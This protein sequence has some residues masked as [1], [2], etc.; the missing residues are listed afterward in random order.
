MPRARKTKI[1]SDTSEPKRPR[2]RA[3][4]KKTKPSVTPISAEEIAAEAYGLF[5][6]RNGQ[7]GDALADWLAAERLVRDRRMNG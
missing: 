7:H 4:V 6:A 2:R 1:A 3:T 5:L